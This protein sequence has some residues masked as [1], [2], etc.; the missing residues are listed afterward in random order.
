MPIDMMIVKIEEENKMRTL[1][2]M[3][4]GDILVNEDGD[5]VKI[6]EVMS[7]SFLRSSIFDH[8]MAYTWYTFEEAE[9]Y[10]LKIQQEEPVKEMTHS[11]VEE[12]L[13]YKVKVVEG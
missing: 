7:N 5:T 12:A 13:G 10:G 4:V 11:E 6:L 2:E 9:K 3:K 8:S 1:R